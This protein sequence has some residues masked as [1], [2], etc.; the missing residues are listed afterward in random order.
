[1]TAIQ[2][3]PLKTITGQDAKLADYAGK[4]LLVVNVASKCG[5]T[6]QYEALE[7][8]YAEKKDQGLVVMGFP[9]NDFGA[10]EPGTN[11]E[12]QDFCST[13]YGVDFPM[14]A[15]IEV[16]GP[17]IHPLYKALTEA[18]PKADGPGDAFRKR[19]EGF[20]RAANPEP[21]ILWNFEK[22]VIGKDGK[23]VG[24]FAPNL[25]PDDPMVVETIDKALSA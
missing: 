15:K 9:A 1:M 10:Q 4:V 23:V 7:K 22:F 25:A 14:F 13:N 24:R 5:L 8:L 16:T 19:L 6:P 3:V 12:I 2:D 11:E 21:G 18:W 17:Q 20:G